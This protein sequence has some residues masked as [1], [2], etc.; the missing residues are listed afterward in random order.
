MNIHTYINQPDLI[1]TLTPAQKTQLFQDLQK[2]LTTLQQN[3]IKFESQLEVK[4]QEQQKLFQE[5]QEQTGL[6]TV[7]DMQQYLQNQQQAFDQELLKI[8]Q[9][10][11][12]IQN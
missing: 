12:Q 7:V 6:T 3:K 10:F 11:N 1:K 2:Y 8:V 5:L 4:Q 9:Q